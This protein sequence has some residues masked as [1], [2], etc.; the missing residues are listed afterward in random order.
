MQRPTDSGSKPRTT[1]EDALM[2]WGEL[3]YREDSLGRD[4]EEREWQETAL[5]YQRRQWLD[6]N[7]NERRYV[8]MEPD[9]RKPRPMPV[10]NYFAKAVNENANQLGA[11]LVRV[12]ATPKNDDPANRRA[13]D[14][15]QMGKLAIDQESNLKVLNPLLAKHTALWGMGCLKDEI[16]T[17]EDQE[18]IDD[19]EMVSNKSLGC[20]DC[21]MIHDIG[22]G[23][24]NAD[25]DI[26][27]QQEPCPECNSSNTMSW[28]TQNA[29]TVSQYVTGKGKIKTRVVPV[30]EVYLPRDCQNANL[31]DRVIHR[32]RRSLS[33][34]VRLWGEKA[35]DLKSDDSSTNK[36]EIRM[37][38]LRSLSSVTYADKMGNETATITEVWVKWDAIPRKL[39]DAI[40]D[41]LA[42]EPEE[43][44]DEQ[45]PQ[46]IAQQ[47]AG[48]L[49]GD[50]LGEVDLEQM[51]KY[52]L[53]MIFAQGIMLQWGPN[54]FVDDDTEEC[55]FPFTFYLWDVDPASV[56][57]K[58]V[59]ADLVPL[60]KRLNRLDSLIELAMMTNAAG[61]WLWPKTQTTKPP[62]GDP[63]DVAEYDPIGEGKTKP[64]F[65]QPKPFSGDV[66]QYRAS[67]LQDFQELGNSSGVQQG[68][69]PG[70]GAAFRTVA[71]LGAKAAEQLNT[72]RFLWESA[73][74]MHY[75]KTLAMAKMYWDEERQVK[76]AGP[77]GKFLFETFSG[78]D[79]KGMYEL[80]FVKD[81]SVPRTMEEKIELI[82]T[83]IAGG[84]VEM[85]DPT[86]RQY[87][88]DVINLEGLNLLGELQFRKA[89]RDLEAVK[90][91]EMPMESPYQDWNVE[92]KVVAN[93]TLTEEFEVMDPQL[94]NYVLGFCEYINEKVTQIQQAQQMQQMMAGMAGPMAQG[95]M[96]TASGADDPN[97]SPLQKVP[98]KTTGT[99]QTEG[100]AKKQGDKFAGGLQ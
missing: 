27:Q 42:P 82:Q 33:G 92:L 39:Q 77:N 72:Q 20:L 4:G 81:S 35:E 67:I 75:K 94:Q 36:D 52:G 51:K 91:G 63:S 38:S 25:D 99:S 84:L 100:A 22:G 53:F 58:G 5:F 9:K 44:G 15:A 24:E 70:A 85:S 31:T 97:K 28:Q 86:V 1:V 19:Q 11:E 46:E 14:Y 73:H 95:A 98:G 50:Q 74:C 30:F 68:E 17:T 64:E 76:V 8:Q 78:D 55:F 32:Y 71:Y 49:Q 60:Q 61:K 2:G 12:T 88:Y 56:Y 66:W 54:P 3:K 87:I 43:D 45:D 47:V 65:V 18:E 34:A 79:L 90:R 29:S 69:S 93:F 62:S 40:E 59:G 16:D 13:A 23:A 83:L 21:G 41:E 48:M 10:S 96:K 7:K 6:W 26:G 57:P 37:D 80:E 89:E